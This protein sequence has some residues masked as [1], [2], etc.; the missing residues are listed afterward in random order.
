MD[1][2]EPPRDGIRLSFSLDG[3]KEASSGYTKKYWKQGNSTLKYAEIFNIH[4]WK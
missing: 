1:G 4:Y 2:R 3:L